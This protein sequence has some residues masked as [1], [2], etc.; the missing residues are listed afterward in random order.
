MPVSFGSASVKVG[1]ETF[2]HPQT[3]IVAAGPSP[4]AEDRSVVVFAGL[5]TEGLWECVGRFPDRGG[6]TAEVLLFEAGG[7]TRR[8]AI[9]SPTT[10]DA[11]LT[12]VGQ[13]RRDDAK[14]VS[15]QVR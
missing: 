6:A 13:H 12:S 14:A 9:A 10:G 2:A 5:G 7:P 1:G 11:P 4:M 8:L 15:S 3:A